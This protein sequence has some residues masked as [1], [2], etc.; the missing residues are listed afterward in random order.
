HRATRNVRPSMTRL[1]SPT[2][3]MVPGVGR[4]G[5]VFPSTTSAQGTRT[6][7]GVIRLI[8]VRSGSSTQR[9][10]AC[11]VAA[12]TVADLGG[13]TSA[14]STEGDAAT[15]YG[16][17]IWRP[18]PRHRYTK[19]P[20]LAPGATDGLTVRGRLRCR[21]GKSCRRS[22]WIF[23]EACEPNIGLSGEACE[24]NIG[25]SGEACEPSIGLSGEACE[26]NFGLSGEACEPR[27][28]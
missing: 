17:A 16:R 26:P 7:S 14:S 28:Q 21:H 25:L 10:T 4:A 27:T 20:A 5:V 15:G 22:G 2:V 6:A 8:M 9:Y 1:P 13:P 18:L 19:C 3:P 12:T 11:L 24:P 23:G